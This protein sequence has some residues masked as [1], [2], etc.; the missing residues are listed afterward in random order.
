MDGRLVLAKRPLDENQ[1]AEGYTLCGH[2]QKT[3]EVFRF[4]FGI[5]HEPSRLCMKWLEFFRI[6]DAS[7]EFLQTMPV[8]CFLHDIGKANT[9]FQD[10]VRGKAGFQVIRHEHLSG[11]LL[12][13]PKI[14]R[15][16]EQAGLSV[17]LVVSAIIGHHLKADHDHF[18]DPVNVD[19]TSFRVYSSH[20][21]DLLGTTLQRLGVPI[22]SLPVIPEV[23]SFSGTAGFDPTGLIS[24]TKRDLHRFRRKLT[25]DRSQ[26]RLLPA[27]RSALILADSAASGLVRQGKSIQEWIEAAFDKNQ[28]L[29]GKAVQEK[30]LLPRVAQIERER[31]NFQWRDFQKAAGDL[32]KRALMISS[33]GSGKTLAAWRWI[34]ARARQHPVSRVI[35]LYPTRGTATLTLG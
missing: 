25:E 22:S 1:P 23:W 28:L 19:L 20:V 32:P 2:S 35:F 15:P 17:N 8:V 30:V 9:G 26:L 29:N 34:E 27:M 4:M 21:G 5:E 16:L 31:G 14:R 7:E 24:E 18:G 33:C 13:M 12:M 11:L 6:A 3:S 10:A